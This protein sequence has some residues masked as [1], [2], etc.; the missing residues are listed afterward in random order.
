MHLAPQL[1]G[2]AQSAYA[3]MGA[4]DTL[5]Y[6]ALKEA[7]LKRYDISKDT[8]MYKHRF[9][10]SEKEEASVSELVVQLNYV[11]RKW[12]RECETVK[13]LVDLMVMDQLLNTLQINVKIWMTQDIG[14]GSEAGK[15]TTCSEGD[16][17]AASKADGEEMIEQ[18]VEKLKSTMTNSARLSVLTVVSK[19]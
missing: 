13:Q 5:D 3:A 10:K 14:R 1:M 7:I 8:Y 6:W 4:E 18:L 16:T 9:Q 11:F 15:T 2:K 17:Y 19:S 12:T